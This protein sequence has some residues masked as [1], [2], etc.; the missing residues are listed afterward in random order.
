MHCRLLVSRGTCLQCGITL[1]YYYAEIYLG[2]DRCRHRCRAGRDWG[3]L[4]DPCPLV[5]GVLMLPLR[6]LELWMDPEASGLVLVGAAVGFL[7]SGV[8][9]GPL[10]TCLGGVAVG[11][12]LL[13]FPAPARGRVALSGLSPV[14]ISWDL[15][16]MYGHVFPGLLGR[17][18]ALVGAPSAAVCHR[19]NLRRRQQASPLPVLFAP[20]S[21]G[22]PCPSHECFGR[23]LTAW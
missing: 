22:D 23:R 16:P 12:S 5:V 15:S 6:A 1:Y 8:P 18:L 3:R 4:S 21:M 20:S 10:L 7:V 9:T 2:R 17:R 11:A 13:K 19:C 14:V